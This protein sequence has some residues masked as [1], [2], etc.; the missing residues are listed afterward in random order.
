MSAASGWLPRSEFLM[1][2]HGNSLSEP[3]YRPGIRGPRRK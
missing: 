2:P 1:K 3:D